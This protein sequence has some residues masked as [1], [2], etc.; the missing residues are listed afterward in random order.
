MPAEVWPTRRRSSVGERWNSGA[1]ERSESS[2]PVRFV[3]YAVVAGDGLE[4]GPVPRV[5]MAFTVHV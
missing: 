5:L 1:D 2:A 4:V 3:G